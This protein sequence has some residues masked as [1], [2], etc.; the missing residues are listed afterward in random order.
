[1]FQTERISFVHTVRTCE[2]SV[3]APSGQHPVRR[4]IADRPQQN[5]LKCEVLFPTN[6]ERWNP[7]VPQ[8]RQLFDQR[9]Q[10]HIE[11][12]LRVVRSRD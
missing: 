5:R 2:R 7:D 3:G 8:I 4:E 1:M 11:T 12:L 9:L 6:V 10:K